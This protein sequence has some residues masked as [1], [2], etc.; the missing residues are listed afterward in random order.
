[1]SREKTPAEIYIDP[2]CLM[3]VDPHKQHPTYTYRMRTYHFC[4]DS[5]CRAFENN[6]ENYLSEKPPPKKNLWRR[7]LDRLNKATGGKPPSCCQ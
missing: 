6:P 1:M 3:R 2:V 5:C 7:Y 4:A